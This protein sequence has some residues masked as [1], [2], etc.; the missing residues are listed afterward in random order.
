ME[1]R[2]NPDYPLLV[3]RHRYG[4]SEQA[5]FHAQGYLQEG[6]TRVN[7]HS[8]Y[9]KHPAKRRKG[10]GSKPFKM[11][12]EHFDR[13]DAEGFLYMLKPTEALETRP[14]DDLV[15]RS[16]FSQSEIT[17]MIECAGYTPR[18]LHAHIARR[19]CMFGECLG[20]PRYMYMY[21]TVCPTW[22]EGN[23]ND[24]KMTFSMATNG[25]ITFV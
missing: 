4:K 22:S 5:H 20:R 16:N 3:V 8:T 13:A 9:E 23:L 11:K 2:F 12:K 7:E 21:K 24:R 17:T 10:K 15:I 18:L 14:R 1:S 19:V 6:I 25:F